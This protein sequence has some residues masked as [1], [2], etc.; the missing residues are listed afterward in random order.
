MQ[1]WRVL[2][3]HHV[4]DEALGGDGVRVAS[5]REEDWDDKDV[6]PDCNPP[7]NRREEKSQQD[8]CVHG[9]CAVIPEDE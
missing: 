1:P 5:K 2:R 7:E 6:G 8:S 4:F 3:V 9:E